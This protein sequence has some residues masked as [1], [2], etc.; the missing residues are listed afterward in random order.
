MIC[1]QG[2][3]LP[4]GFAE[5]TGV[6]GPH[7]TMAAPAPFPHASPSLRGSPVPQGPAALRSSPPPPTL[8]ETPAPYSPTTPLTP[9]ILNSHR[10]TRWLRY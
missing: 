4:P 6:K 10:Q 5:D 1:G 9:L 7:S 8:A 2:T 3:N